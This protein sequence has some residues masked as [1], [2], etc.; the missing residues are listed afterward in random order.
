MNN[1]KYAKTIEAIENNMSE[2]IEEII[3][4]QQTQTSILRNDHYLVKD[5]DTQAVFESVLKKNQK[6]SAPNNHLKSYD[7]MHSNLKISVKSGQIKN[8][9]L[10]FSYSRTTEHPTLNDKIEYLAKFDNLIIGIASE[11]IKSDSPQVISKTKYYLYYFPADFIDIKSMDFVET[12]N[13]W[14]G[15]DKARGIN[16]DIVK[17]MS[18]QPWITM[19]I[20]LIPCK[21]ILT[22][23]VGSHQN[24]KYLVIDR[25]D[26][27][28]R[29]YFDI[30][31]QRK[32]IRSLTGMKK[33]TKFM[34]NS[35]MV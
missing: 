3:L 33:C 6:K 15:K 13:C 9:N 35:A 11:K 30:Y 8:D 4:L 17:K 7:F 23:T 12:D 22:A 18:D 28:E 25:F 2:I 27:N 1:G 16:M 20:N 31:D 26:K 10:K 29:I 5:K 32:K 21:R 24:R 34:Q 19:P 14:Q